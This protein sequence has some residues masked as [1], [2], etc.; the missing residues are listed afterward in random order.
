MGESLVSV[1]QV[2]EVQVALVWH[3]SHTAKGGFPTAQPTYR[4]LFLTSAPG[5]Q[6]QVPSWLACKAT[7]KWGGGASACTLEISWTLHIIPPKKV[8]RFV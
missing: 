4:Q 6:L 7:F 5:A 8:Q 2:A 3:T 1:L